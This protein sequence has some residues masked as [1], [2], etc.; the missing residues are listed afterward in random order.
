MQWP[1][2]AYLPIQYF[3]PHFRKRQQNKTKYSK[4][5][6]YLNKMNTSGLQTTTEK[7]KFDQITFLFVVSLAFQISYFS[8][9]D[10]FNFFLFVILYFIIHILMLF[11][12]FFLSPCRL[13]IICHQLGNDV[14]K[15]F[16]P[17][18]DLPWLSDVRTQA[19]FHSLFLSSKWENYKFYV[20]WN[21]Y[22]IQY[23]G[24]IMRKI[25]LLYKTFTNKMLY[26]VTYVSGAI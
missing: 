9:V 20:A 21:A 11:L 22:F 6:N 4:N 19:L 24:T 1:K 12:T 18:F 17:K 26:R 13:Y 14:R 25:Q 8:S 23:T 7:W 2:V 5:R 15:H 16:S 10:M 3:M